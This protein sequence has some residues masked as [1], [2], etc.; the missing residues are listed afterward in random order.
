[1]LTAAR[2]MAGACR[3]P[4]PVQEMQALCHLVDMQV[5]GLG[6]A[7]LL[8]SQAWTV[9]GRPVAAAPHAR[10]RAH[11]RSPRPAR[12]L[13]V[14]LCRPPAVAAVATAWKPKGPSPR[15]S[16]GHPWM[17][18]MMTWQAPELPLR[19]RQQQS[20]AHHP[21]PLLLP[22]RPVQH[23]L[24][25]LVPPAVAY[26]RNL[27]RPPRMAWMRKL[28]MKCPSCRPPAPLSLRRPSEPLAAHVLSPVATLAP[29]APQLP[30][31]QPRVDMA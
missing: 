12:S 8:R 9:R 29:A 18:T 17:M 26:C 22:L 1:M 13:A 31:Q 28:M 30:H 19:R 24:L 6:L 10:R 11:R 15:S 23:L 27:Y 14:A 5:Q 16:H 20:S 3:P 21:S 2:P 25:L 7:W 4:C